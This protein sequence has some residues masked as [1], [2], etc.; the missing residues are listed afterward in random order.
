[1][2]IVP[3]VLSDAIN[4]KLDAAFEKVPEAAKD[5]DVLYHKLLEYFDEYGVVPDFDVVPNEKLKRG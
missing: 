5:R 2:V 4:K 3:N 1:M